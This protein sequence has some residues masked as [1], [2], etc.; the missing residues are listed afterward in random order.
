[1]EG[2]NASPLACFACFF[3]SDANFVHW[4]EMTGPLRRKLEFGPIAN[5]DEVGGNPVNR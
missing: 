2:K 5:G 3:L 1:M 4:P